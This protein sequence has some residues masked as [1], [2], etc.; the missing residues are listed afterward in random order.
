MYRT[1]PLKAYWKLLID[2]DL[3]HTRLA[4]E[5][6][7]SR[8]AIFRTIRGDLKSPRLRGMIARRLGV[9]P[10]F[11]GWPDPTDKAA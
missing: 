11:F 10:S 6:G 8:T 2:K 5:L 4:E 3:L 1:E 7:V 9:P